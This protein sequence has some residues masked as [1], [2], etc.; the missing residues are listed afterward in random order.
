VTETPSVA[1][2]IPCFHIDFNGLGGS[3]VPGVVENDLG[4]NGRPVYRCPGGDCNQNPGHL[5]TSS[6][7]TRP[8]FNGPGPFSEWYDSSSPNAIEVDQELTLTR[9]AGQGTYVYDA[10]LSFYPLNG[11]G[12]VAQG[13]EHVADPGCPNNVSFTS[14]AHFWF[15]YQGGE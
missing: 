4:S 8:N 5:F 1:K 7:N 12:W 6:G 14:E 13:D 15:E 2:P 9:N 10:N 11:K 3:G